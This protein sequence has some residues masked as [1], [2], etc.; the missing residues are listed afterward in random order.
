M[1]LSFLKMIGWYRF[2]TWPRVQFVC[3]G[4]LGAYFML[5]L[6][7]PEWSGNVI[8]FSYV[9]ECSRAYETDRRIH[10]S[11]GYRR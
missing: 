1:L 7:F 11:D 8:K 5:F 2:K 6:A 4:I 3:G 9:W 10:R